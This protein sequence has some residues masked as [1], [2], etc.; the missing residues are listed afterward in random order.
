MSAIIACGLNHKT[1]PL[2]IR[3]RLAFDP[4]ETDA[5]LHYIVERGVAKEVAILSTCNRTEIYCR[6]KDSQ[7]LIDWLGQNRTLPTT[8]LQPHLYCHQGQ[9]AVQHMLRVANGLDSMVLGEPQILGQ[10]KKAFAQA[11]D[12]GTLGPHLH[13]LSQHIFSVS[14]QIRTNTNIG[15]NSVSIAYL[16]VNLAKRIF[17]DLQQRRALLIG[18]GETIELVAKYLHTHN[19]QTLFV[20]NRTLSK[21]QHIAAQY[22]G[23]AITLHDVPKYLPQADIVIS[24]TKSSLPILGKGGIESAL[25]TRKHNPMLML[26]IA[27]PRD[28][29]AEVGQL[30]DVY[31]YTIDDL[32]QMAQDN[33]HD[34]EVAAQQ[35]EQIILTQT[36]EF[37]RWRETLANIDIARTYRDVAIEMRDQALAKQLDALRNGEAA[38][39]VLSRLAHQLT[40]KLLH[41]PTVHI[42]QHAPDNKSE[43]L[44]LARKLFSIE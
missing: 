14:K 16:A 22:Q 20:A 28:I 18:A 9:N 26:D 32:Q 37:M 35:A 41:Q 21:A 11:N 40:N 13:K 4:T 2:P 44:A 30:S 31:L 15:T 43:I 25:K 19:I 38:E 7:P 27:V 33:L 34:R 17:A 29:E 36:N 8:Q 42:K 10:M 24:A 6:A 23:Q 1:A 39:A 3:E 12:R 5:C